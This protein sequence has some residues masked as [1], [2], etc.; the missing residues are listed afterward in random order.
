MEFIASNSLTMAETILG[1]SKIIIQIIGISW[2]LFLP[3][4]LFFIWKEFWIWGKNYLW[5][6]KIKWVLLEIK[7]PRNIE[8]TPKAMENV[9]TNL[10]ALYYKKPDFEDT[11]FKGEEILWFTCELVGYAGGVHF[12]IRCPK[13][14]RNLVESAV[15]SEYPDAEIIEE[16]DYTELMPDI[17]P[18][19]TYDIWGQDFILAK[20]SA[21]PIRTYEFFEENL[22]ERRL[23]SIASVTEVMS[24]LTEGEAI[25]LQYLIRPVP[26]DFK[27]WKIEGEKIRD[28]IMQRKKEKEKG[29]LQG[30]ID[31]L[32]QFFKN[33]SF[34]SV[35]YP[36][37]ADENQ[38]KEERI[39][40][41]VL[42]PGEQ[43]AL[44]G[45]ENK[46]SKLGFETVIRFVYIDRRDSF[47][48]QNISAVNG[49]IKQFNTQDMN[50]FRQAKETVTYVT[51]KK[52]TYRSWFRK[53][54][55][56]YR[57]RMM[58]DLYKM[59]WFPSKS[60]VLNAEELATV[61]HFPLVSVKAP[62][63]Q[64]LGT[65]KGEPPANVPIR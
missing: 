1:I 45:L 32:T 47:T 64:R 14:F 27:D 43:N 36:V 31:G 22:A 10:H 54:K 5:K 29:F 38:K 33:L 62:L 53:Q 51:A 65:R 55:L 48:Y 35:E 24:R 7:I 41:L 13:G 9:F 37:W 2:W 18:D 56:F 16:E 23:D 63:L 26:D 8:K 6:L 3:L 19:D 15:Y 21:Y 20:E 52:L 34:A 42:S 28:K 12:Y 50:R 61:F 17:I 25:W 11:Y 57:K 40:F 4:G 30:L 60:S 39:K 58:Y 44:K 49:M 59:R 46:I